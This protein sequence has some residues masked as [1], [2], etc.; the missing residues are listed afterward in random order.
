MAQEPT[1]Y[2][3]LQIAYN[4]I[5]R[6]RLQQLRG[7]ADEWLQLPGELR[8]ILNCLVFADEL[9]EWYFEQVRLGFPKAVPAIVQLAVASE[10][11]TRLSQVWDLYQ[12]FEAAVGQPPNGIRSCGHT[13]NL[14]AVPQR[15]V[16]VSRS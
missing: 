6:E 13:G 15:T 10:A 5:P 2:E 3:K 16:L 11:L 4:R 1:V 7:S 12:R 9:A 8:I 14:A